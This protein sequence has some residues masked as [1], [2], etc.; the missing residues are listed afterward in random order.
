MKLTFEKVT[1][2]TP[3]V[4]AILNKWAHDPLLVPLMH[5]SRNKEELEAPTLV[6]VESC[7]RSLEH[8]ATFFLRADVGKT[9]W[10]TQSFGFDDVML[11]CYRNG[12][13]R[14]AHAGTYN[15]CQAA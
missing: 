10:V 7:A 12:W 8:N 14:A 6:T 9:G 11:I 5:P 2:P 3:E 15:S 4:A 13:S 1:T